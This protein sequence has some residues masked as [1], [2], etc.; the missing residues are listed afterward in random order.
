MGLAPEKVSPLAPP[1]PKKTQVR[2]IGYVTGPPAAAS[3]LNCNSPP[4]PPIVLPDLHLNAEVPV[5]RS[6]S[7]SWIT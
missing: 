5:G 7:L 6:S 2:S 1:P 4:Q 3:G